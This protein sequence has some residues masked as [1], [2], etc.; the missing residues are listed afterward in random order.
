MYQKIK[1]IVIKWKNLGNKIWFP[2]A[3]IVCKKWII[4]NWTYKI[5]IIYNNDIY[6][7][8]WMFDEKKEIFEAYIF[9]F[10]K[11]IYEEEIQI[12]IHEKIRDNK[13]FD[14]FDELK[15]QIKEDIIIIK[16][17]QDYVLTFWTFDIIHPWHVFFLNQAKYY[18][19][20]LITI[21]A[22]D[23]NI[24]KFKWKNPLYNSEKRLNDVKSLQISDRVFIWE[25]NNP[26]IWVDLYTPNVI[27]LWYDQVWFSEK[28]KD[29]IKEKNLDIEI[30]RIEP[31]KEN[32]Y[33]SSLIKKRL[34]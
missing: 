24:K 30:I 5:N 34:K 10:N 25:S 9:N 11:S 8:A 7:W 16:K 4:K 18:W 26:L 31:Y 29:Y 19:D 20:R 2:T 27:C 12:I 32:I 15:K 28:L 21:V 14:S 33:K 22:T 1:G 3:I 6:R 17:R 13:K 23:K